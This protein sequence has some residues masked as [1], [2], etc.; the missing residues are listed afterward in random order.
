LLLFPPRTVDHRTFTH[1]WE[2]STD[3]D[4][5]GSEIRVPSRP[6][7]TPPENAGRHALEEHAL[8][9]GN[10]QRRDHVVE[11]QVARAGGLRE[12]GRLTGVV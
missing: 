9:P 5:L 12:L 4:P 11:E 8:E 10:R 1:G 3:F 2:T 7:V 6:S